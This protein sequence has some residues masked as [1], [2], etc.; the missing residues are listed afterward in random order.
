MALSSNSGEGGEFQQQSSGG[1]E[2]DVRTRRKFL[3]DTGKKAA[4][5]VPVVLSLT[6]Q[7]VMAASGESCSAYGADCDVNEDCC[8]LNCHGPTM[9]CKGEI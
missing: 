5:V 2:A 4:F 8:S 9:T 3:T 1:G 6:A 7:P